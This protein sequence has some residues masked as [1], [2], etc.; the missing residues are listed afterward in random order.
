M[1]TYIHVQTNNS[2]CIFIYNHNAILEVLIEYSLYCLLCYFNLY[3]QGYFTDLV[4]FI[5][6]HSIFTR[7]K[8]GLYLTYLLQTSCFLFS[9]KHAALTRANIDWF[10]ITIMCQC[11]DMS[12]STLLFQE[13]NTIKTQPSMFV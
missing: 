13:A 11:S 3:F 5:T 2:V 4:L 1:H 7:I 8:M 9:A 12:T 6:S 10:G